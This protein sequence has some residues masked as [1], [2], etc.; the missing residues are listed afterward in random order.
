MILASLFG[1]GDDSPMASILSTFSTGDVEKIK[2]NIFKLPE[3]FNVVFTTL[4]ILSLHVNL[5]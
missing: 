2:E 3:H 1:R 4:A 5:K